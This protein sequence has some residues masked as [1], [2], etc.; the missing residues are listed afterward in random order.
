MNTASYIS[1]V[2]QTD[3]FGIFRDEAL[4]KGYAQRVHDHQKWDVLTAQRMTSGVSSFVEKIQTKSGETF[5]LKISP[6][7]DLP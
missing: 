5:I 3:R 6:L 2:V 4:W 7:D 1:D